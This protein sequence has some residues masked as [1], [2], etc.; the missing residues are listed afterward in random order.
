MDVR[1]FLNRRIAFIKQ[2]YVT[3]SDPFRERKRKIEAEEEPF[4][5]TYS[6]DGEPP[7]LEE[8]L[9][10][11]ESLQVIGRSCISMLSATLHLYFKTWERQIGISVDESMKP[12]FKKGWFHGYKAY[13]ARHT[14]IKF[15]NGPSNLAML[16]E[17]VLARNRIQ[18]PDS[19]TYQSTHY[20]DD[21]LQKIP[22]PFFVDEKEMWLITESDEDQNMWLMPPTISVSQESLFAALTEVERFSEWLEQVEIEEH[23]RN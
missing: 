5:P 11:E 8:W 14:G 4:I 19:I 15:E 1:F 9:E 17:L 22:H 10:A 18:H 6:E 7:F 2:L 21:D 16:E 13:F 3:A 20:A 23:V 12:D